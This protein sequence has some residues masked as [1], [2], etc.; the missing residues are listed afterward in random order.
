MRIFGMTEYALALAAKYR[1]TPLPDHPVDDI[2]GDLTT[3]NFAE[4]SFF[5]TT[6]SFFK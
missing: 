6:F 4:Y 1:E 5:C 2:G 3:N